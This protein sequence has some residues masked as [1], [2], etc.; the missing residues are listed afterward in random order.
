MPTE[1]INGLRHHYLDVGEGRPLVLVHGAAS[2]SR[3]FDDMVP[4]LA[5]HRRVIAPDLRGMGRSERITGMDADSWSADLVALVE[6]LALQH[7]D[8]AGTSLGA[9]IALRLAL[10]C[11][12]R[13]ERLVLD[14][15][16][17]WAEPTGSALLDTI[18]GPER[19]ADM[20]EHL[21]RWH[22]EDWEAVALTYLELRHT[23]GLQEHYDFRATLEQVRCSTLVTRGDL[24]D[25]IH[26]LQHAV[27]VHRRIEAT[28]L[29]VEPDTPFSLARFCPHEWARRLLEHVG[30]GAVSR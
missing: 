14:A 28:S 13:V 11:P 7:L 25:P 29:W 8:V 23:P 16:M 27:D 2:S 12:D 20:E 24:D 6:R 15:P 30:T 9:R 18:F 3:A 19:S 22:G 4:L 10:D 5:R 26:P 1:T 21:Q 17:I